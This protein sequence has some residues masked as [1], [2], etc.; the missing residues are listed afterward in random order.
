MIRRPPRSTRTDTLFPYTT[1][2]RSDDPSKRN[3]DDSA[4]HM[5]KA[6]VHNP[7]F[8][9]STDRRPDRPLHESIIYEVH[10]KGFT[11]RHPGIPEGLRGTYG[12]P[13]HPPASEHPTTLGLPTGETRPENSR[14]GKEG[15]RTI[16]H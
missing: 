12:G 10:A 7:Y 14:E 4:P 6:V 15:G 9:W 5:P 8:D 13:D 11:A 1:L 3:D 2:F 16:S